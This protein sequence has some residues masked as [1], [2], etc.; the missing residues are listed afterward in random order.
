[1]VVRTNATPP[2]KTGIVIP[3]S[4]AKGPPGNLKELIT[5]HECES[6]LVIFSKMNSG[7]EL[8]DELNIKVTVD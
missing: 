7:I 8:M 3:N 4:I 2:F 5:T 1:M 6:A